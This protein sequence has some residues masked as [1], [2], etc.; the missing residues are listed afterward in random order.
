MEVDEDWAQVTGPSVRHQL[1]WVSASASLSLGP[2]SQEPSFLLQLP[3]RG[4]DGLCPAD[5]HPRGGG[6]SLVWPTLG[7]S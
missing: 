5:P 2:C 3:H 7:K 1:P 6:H 4:S